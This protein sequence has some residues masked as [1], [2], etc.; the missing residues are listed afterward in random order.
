AL[1]KRIANTPVGRQVPLLVLRQGQ[2]QQVTMTTQRRAKTEG[3]QKDHPQWGFTVREVTQEMATS[4]NLP[5]PGGVMVT[6]VKPGSFAAEA[7][8]RPGDL[9]MRL[10]NIEIEDLAHWSQAAQ[11]AVEQATNRLL[12]TVK[13]GPVR[14]FVVLKPI[15]TQPTALKAPASSRKSS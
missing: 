6:G 1:E 10:E 9:V 4:L 13:R 15:Y 11:E 12:L 3:G 5:G 7:G 2:H 14:Y 8:L